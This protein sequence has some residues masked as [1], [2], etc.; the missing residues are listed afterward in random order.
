M[1]TG[2]SIISAG[3]L[4]T[5]TA[6]SPFGL[7][8]DAWA[9][10]GAKSTPMPKLI[11]D[12]PMPDV[13]GWMDHMAVDVKGQRLFVPAEQ[14]KAMQVIDLRTNKVIKSITGF[15]G[16]PR[17]TIYIPKSNQLWVD[18]GD[19]VKAFD[20][21]TYQ[22][23]KNIPFNLDKESKLIPDNGNY[24]PATG[25]FYVTVTADANSA[26]AT[27]KGSVEIV[28]TKTATRVGTIK[29]DGTDPSGIAFDAVTPRM[30]VIMGDTAKVQVID[31][32]TRETVATWDITGGTQPHTVAIDTEHHRLFVGSRIKSGH[33]FK[34]GKMVVMDTDTGKVVAAIDT[35]GGADEIQYDRASKRI[36]FT[37]TTGHVDVIK[38]VD[39]DHYE[40]LGKLVTAADAK[41]S[42]LVPELKRFYVG[43]PKRNVAI[44][45]S[46]D[47]ITEDCTILVFEVP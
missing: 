13:E 14:Q 20:M 6:L 45:P 1:R 21:G 26:T 43:V 32:N 2:L 10:K 41:T 30:F 29:L 15:D 17:K 8:A 22:L 47:V 7:A 9:A 27:V 40:P 16:N 28:D 25:L 12:I 35:E 5:L 3:V 23:I 31:R 38:Q 42:L 24:D 39:A 11:G 33:I 37:G 18:D 46:R 4:A 36:Y 44:P 19:S 34:P